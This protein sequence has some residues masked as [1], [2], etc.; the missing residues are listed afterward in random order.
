MLIRVELL[1]QM[2]DCKV[3]DPQFNLRSL[4]PTFCHD[5]ALWLQVSQIYVVKM[6]VFDSFQELAC[7]L[8][9]FILREAALDVC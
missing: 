2:H 1:D 4:L 5:D 3:D 9:D 7:D 8:A 6:Q